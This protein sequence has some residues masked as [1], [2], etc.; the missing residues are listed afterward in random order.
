[1]ALKIVQEKI[2]FPRAPRRSR[3]PIKS[4]GE[5]GNPI[6]LATK[7]RQGLEG[8][9]LPNFPFDLKEISQLSEKRKPVD[10]EAETAM[11]KLLANEKKVTAAAAKIENLLARQPVQLQVLHAFDIGFHPL[12]DLGVFRHLHVR[13]CIARLDLLDATLVEFIEQGPQWDGMESALKA[14]PAALVK[15]P[16]CELLDLVREFHA[17]RLSA[18]RSPAQRLEGCR[19]I[20]AFNSKQQRL[21]W[22]SGNRH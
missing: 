15:F 12:L 18:M 5:T 16:L 3:R 1:M 2:P 6:K 21:R 4:G 10:V 14:T 13:R 7:I 22:R 20:L 11:S 8:V 19:V 9:D 17:C